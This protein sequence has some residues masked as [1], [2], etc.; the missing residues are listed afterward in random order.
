MPMA[1]TI[2]P[3]TAVVPL[4]TRTPILF[5]NLI[6]AAV[7]RKATTP[8]ARLVNQIFTVRKAKF[9]PTATASTDVVKAK[10][11]RSGSLEMLE[12]FLASVRGCNDSQRNV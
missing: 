6:A 2:I 3:P 8:I 1:I 12:D 11:R 7:A 4:P 9:T 10:V 5:P